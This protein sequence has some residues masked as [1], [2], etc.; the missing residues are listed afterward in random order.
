MGTTYSTF[1]NSCDRLDI[2]NIVDDVNRVI[3]CKDPKTLIGLPSN[4]ASPTDIYLFNFK[5]VT[6]YKGEDLKKGI[7]K[8]FISDVNYPATISKNLS[9]QSNSIK[10]EYYIYKMVTSKILYHNI[11]PHFVKFL[12]GSLNISYQQLKDY[13]IDSSRLS[14]SVLETNFKRNLLYILNSLI[15]RPAITDSVLPPG[16]SP[17]D[18]N[19]INPNS[20]KYGFILTEALDVKSINTFTDYQNMNNGDTI[21]FQ[22]LIDLKDTITTTID[23]SEWLHHCIKILFQIATACYSLF[24]TGT[25]HNDLH[26][27]NILIKKIPERVNLYYIDGKIYKY[28]TTYTAL[29]YDYDRSYNIGFN[30]DILDKLSPSYN[31]T[32]DL[33]EQRDFV[34]C[35]CYIF[36]KFNTSEQNTM[37]N[38]LSSDIPTQQLISNRYKDPSCFLRGYPYT[39]N[40]VTD[41]LKPVHYNK[42]YS[43]P[44]IIDQIASTLQQETVLESTH[45]YISDNRCFQNY[46][47]DNN[48]ILKIAQSIRTR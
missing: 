10:Y 44:K 30:N 31:A 18:I 11:N 12:G 36:K 47:I 32:N 26:C 48:M 20:Y 23:H 28:K 46:Q 35:V 15:N 13:L 19:N 22:K 42:M 38:C 41:F 17:V 21:T 27:G 6:T 34:K 43:L 4:S 39:N 3:S 7:Q 8:I 5:P 1:F 45:V 33:I 2:D 24:L 16:I 14:P 40:P 9:I 25:T 37:L 29:I